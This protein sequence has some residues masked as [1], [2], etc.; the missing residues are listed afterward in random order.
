M[1]TPHTIAKRAGTVEEIAEVITFLS[2]PR[3]SYIWG[4]NIF[5]DGGGTTFAE[6]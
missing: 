5:V 4:A 2:S 6:F 1:V 3:A